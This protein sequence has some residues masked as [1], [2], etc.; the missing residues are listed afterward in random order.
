L[1]LIT[2]KIFQN[3]ARWTNS[4]PWEVIILM[5]IWVV[6]S[7]FTPATVDSVRDIYQ[8][9]AIATG[10]AFP[11][12]GPQLAHTIHLGPLWFYILAI[13]A[14][15]FSTWGSIALF[16][17][18]ISALKFWLAYVFGKEL[19]STQLG[20]L[21]ALFLAL[22]SWS[23][24]Q[25]II[26]TH[27][28]VLETSLLLYLLSLR[29]SFLFPSGWRWLLTG[30]CF[31]LALHAH[32]TALPYIFLLPLVWRSLAQRWHW[33]GWLTLG[34]A[35]PFLPYGFEQLINGFPDLVA[36]QRY[37]AS[38][39]SPDGPLTML[40]LLYS[41]VVIGPNLF[42]KTT[43]PANLAI[44]AISSHWL[45]I[46]TSLLLGMWRLRTA[47]AKLKQLLMWAVATLVVVVVI[48]VLIRARTPWHL[49]Y[50]PSFALAFFYAVLATIAFRPEFR[51]KVRA[52]FATTIIILFLA[53]MA[54][55]SYKLYS[56]TIRF[57]ELVLY[58]VKNLKSRWGNTGLEIPAFDSKAHGD[59]LCQ[60][61]PVVLH[62]PYAAMVDAHVG[63]EAVMSCGKKDNI[64]IGGATENPEYTHITGITSEMS[65]NL[66]SAPGK[67]VGNVHL[68][69]PLA[70]SDA[71]Q[72]IPLA[73]GNKNPPRQLFNG[74][75]SGLQK[76][77]L[78]AETPNVLLISK[79]VGS[80]LALDVQ[81]VT[82]N[83]T[84]AQL[85]IR[86]NYSWLYRCSE[87]ENHTPMQWQVWYVS[88]AEN[89][90]DA[91]L[92]PVGL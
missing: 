25:L 34:I 59:F 4:L 55:A 29:R 48:V 45:V 86:S 51:F 50:A 78:E 47:E 30:F 68:Y 14:A 64:L 9:N 70:V 74:G 77:E 87:S 67:Q 13:P 2:Q 60:Q 92:L 18:F 28:I 38:E 15:V 37:H 89:L 8:A 32:P 80:V 39:F 63:I 24:F 21:F 23:S 91:V 40:K 82:C 36:L 44:L 7:Q 16:A 35:V 71:G 75:S 84:Q 53:T 1:N 27:T 6:A 3:S 41:I 10:K 54:G 43:L 31:S 12:T 65:K 73:E 11:L 83:G 69:Q 61:A 72:A 42:Y 56:N 81:R 46:L 20:L 85:V 5:S 26:W 52:L 57:Q 19:H 90:I 79:P 88:S 76:L 62:G 49:A 33:I 66:G 22:P 58:D 17:F